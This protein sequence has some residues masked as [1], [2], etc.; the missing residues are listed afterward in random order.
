MNKAILLNGELALEKIRQILIYLLLLSSITEFIGVLL[1][2]TDLAKTAS[3]LGKST[4]Y[5]LIAI[6]VYTLY[7]GEK[8]IFI[9]GGLGLTGSL[10]VML[11]TILK[12]PRPPS[13]EWLIKVEGP[14]FPS[15]HAAMSFSFALLA[16]Y[17]T[18]NPLIALA[19]FIH[20]FAVSDSRLVLHV[21]YPIDV[22]G[23]AILG[24]VVALLS[25]ILYIC[26]NNPGKYLV[27]I[28]IPSLIA[29]IISSIEMPEYTDAPL[30]T[31]L[32]L[33][34]L[35]S[36][37]LIIKTNNEFLYIDRWLFKA[38]SL[39]TAFTGSVIVFILESIN[40]Y[41]AVLMAGSVF[42]ILVLMSRLIAYEIIKHLGRTQ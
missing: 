10:D 12:M 39:F 19:L 29:S 9:I 30:L 2:N 32:S 8:G 15:G 26:F 35:L 7:S 13:S 3:I 11:K 5:M 22:V 21:H 16:G 41:P 25:V 38:I 24:V 14:G 36:G 34:A 28:T 1:E 17:A 33:G 27:S 20:A 4:F 18:R 40:I 6:L 37:L 31:G 23:G 42:S